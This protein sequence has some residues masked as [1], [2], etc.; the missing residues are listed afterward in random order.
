MRYKALP[1]TS[2]IVPE[3][4]LGTMMFGGQ[5]SEAESL[6]IMDYAYDHG[7]NFFD[8]ANSYHVGESEKIVGK[9]LK[10]RREH[11]ILATKVGSPMGDDPNKIGLSRRNLLAALDASLK[12]LNTDFIDIYYL[13]TPDYGT[14]LEETLDT[15]STLVR[16]GKV[17][18]V[19]VSNYAAWQCADMLAICD[20]RGGVAPVVSQN[21]YNLITRGIEAE[22]VPFLE[23]HDMGMVIYNPIAAGLLAGKHK[24]GAPVENT[25]FSINQVYYDRYWSVENFAAVEQLSAI[26]GETG[27]TILELAMKWCAMNARVTSIITGVSKLEQLEM[28]IASVEGEPLSDE[29]LQK[30]DEV[31]TSLAGTRFKYNR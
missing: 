28:N 26:A 22:F 19:G 13:H 1:K 24:P 25:R 2:L 8:T 23:A 9:A 3:L 20:K 6:R 7:L 21:V 30:C 10:G 29:I 11:I 18:Y 12:R 31:W 5:T 16:S 27:L 17:R 14:E 4:C 15:M